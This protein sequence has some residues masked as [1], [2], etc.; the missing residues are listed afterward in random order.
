M[1]VVGTVYSRCT[2]TNLQNQWKCNRVKKKT[3]RNWK[4]KE[5][6]EGRKLPYQDLKGM[7]FLKDQAG[8]SPTLDTIWSCIKLQCTRGSFTTETLI[9]YML[10]HR[11]NLY[12]LW[13]LKRWSR[14]QWNQFQP[15]Q[16]GQNVVAN[17]LLACPA[18]DIAWHFVLD[19]LPPQGG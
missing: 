2:L 1:I 16:Q 8:L 12:P 7:I 5:N 18:N 10:T 17:A 15:F 13:A 4:I 9:Y 3:K 11:E 19:N 14:N 6:R